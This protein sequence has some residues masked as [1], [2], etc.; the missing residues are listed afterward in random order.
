M[1]DTVKY[2]TK[3][4]ISDVKPDELIRI[5]YYRFATGGIGMCRC[6]NNLPEERKILIRIRWTNFKEMNEPEFLNLILDYDGS[7][8]KN[9]SLLNPPDKNQKQQPEKKVIKYDKNE[10]VSGERAPDL[11]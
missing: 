9:F 6:I 3:R 10:N 5:E 11:N 1:V 2:I 7:E 4:K 8:L